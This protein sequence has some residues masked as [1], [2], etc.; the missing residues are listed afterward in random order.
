MSSTYSINE[1]YRDK[2]II[3]IGTNRVSKEYELNSSVRLTEEQATT[4][5]FTYI[6]DNNLLYYLLKPLKRLEISVVDGSYDKQWVAVLE[7]IGESHD[8]SG[9]DYP[10]QPG[11]VQQ[12]FSSVGGTS[13]VTQAYAE[14][15][16]GTNA[17]AM[18]GGI[19]WNGDRFEGVDIVSPTFEFSLTYKYPY[20][21]ITS[22]VRNGWL[23]LVGS[24]NADTFCDFAPGEVLYCGFSGSTVTEYDGSTVVIDGVTYL[25]AQNYYNISHQFKCSPNVSGMSIAGQTGVSKKGWEYLWV[26]REKADDANTGRTIETPTG[27]YVN[28]VYRYANFYGVF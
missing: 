16:Y 6:R 18:N 22:Q 8:A 13:R 21:Q 10:K 27:V 9:N 3:E 15:R 4:L 2:H 11:C 1:R 24:V 20:S 23:S 17:P 26:L 12:A 14:T 28:Q 5:F 25:A 7:W 19:G